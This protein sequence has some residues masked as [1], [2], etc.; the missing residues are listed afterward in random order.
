MP[1]WSS[2]GWVRRLAVVA[3]AATGVG[4]FGTGVRG[5]TQLDGHLADATQGHPAIHQVKQV[6]VGPDCPWRE[7]RDDRQF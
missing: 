7:P 4:L 5:L 6:R 1:R 2:L 3:I